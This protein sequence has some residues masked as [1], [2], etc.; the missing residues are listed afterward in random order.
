M[1]RTCWNSTC[2]RRA[3]WKSS[4]EAGGFLELGD[5]DVDVEGVVS[6]LLGNGITRAGWRW[7]MTGLRDANP[8]ASVQI[9]RDYLVGLGLEL[10]A[11]LT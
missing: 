6:L 7:D 3:R 8:S 10:E 1:T 11:E 9:S 4:G 5:G 2:G